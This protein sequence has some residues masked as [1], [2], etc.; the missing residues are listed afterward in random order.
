MTC[1]DWTRIA[2]DETM[3]YLALAL[4]TFIG[5]CAASIYFHIAHRRGLAYEEITR[6]LHDFRERK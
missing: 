4:G 2:L 5:A 3:I 1:A 6:R